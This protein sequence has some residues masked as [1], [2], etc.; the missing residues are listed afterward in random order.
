MIYL[1]KAEG[2]DFSGVQTI[3]NKLKTSLTHT[4]RNLLFATL[5]DPRFI[6]GFF[7]DALSHR[8][9]TDIKYD[10][11]K[12]N[13]RDPNTE[14]LAKS[15]DSADVSDDDDAPLAKIAKNSKEVNQQ[16]QD[17]IPDSIPH[18]LFWN[19]FEEFI[20]MPASTSKLDREVKD[21]LNSI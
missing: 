20:S 7:D 8:T 2:P 18:S 4:D 3:G 19:T 16:P 1:D 15:N 21:L 12:I 6:T 11:L 5:L 13:G 10:I 17:N 9:Y 14:N